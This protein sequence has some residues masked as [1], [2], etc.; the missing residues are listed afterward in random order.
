VWVDDRRSKP[1]GA[2]SE[3]R[4]SQRS[5][6]GSVAPT[7]TSRSSR[8]W[9]SGTATSVRRRQNAGE[10]AL[11]VA[12]PH[13]SPYLGEMLIRGREWRR[14]ERLGIDSHDVTARAILAA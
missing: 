6:A 10:R 5:H 12:R 8:S 3:S 4:D 7:G 1:I 11:A 2:P 9:T 14:P 13:D